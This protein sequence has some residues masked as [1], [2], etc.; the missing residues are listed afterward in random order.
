MTFLRAFLFTAF[1]S[2]IAACSGEGNQPP[3]GAPI[4]VSETCGPSGRL[5]VSGL[6]RTDVAALIPTALPAPELAEPCVWEMHELALMRK[7][8]FVYRSLS[9]GDVTT[10]LSFGADALAASVKYTSSV[11]EHDRNDLPLW[12][13]GDGTN[14][15]TS[16]AV[17][18]RLILTLPQTQ[19]RDCAL[20]SGGTGF[21]IRAI[22]TDRQVDCGRFG[23]RPVF[24]QTWRDLN[25]YAI[26]S[27]INSD[28]MDIDP[29]SFVIVT[30]TKP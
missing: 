13:F 28:A 15:F 18:D 20:Q 3:L 25:G 30:P 5:P 12:I 10:E 11:F 9:C 23:A 26:F 21:Q 1:A 24:E 6:C 17:S 7:D 29:A 4:A 16:Q 8:V 19:R 14:A 2:T 22:D 27:A